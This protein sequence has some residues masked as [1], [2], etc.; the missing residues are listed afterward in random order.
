[1]YRLILCTVSYRAILETLLWNEITILDYNIYI[2][3]LNL[4]QSLTY[5]FNIVVLRVIDID[6]LVSLE[7]VANP[8]Q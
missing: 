6:N 2:K 3:R 1:M 5:V 8:L 7:L 4:H